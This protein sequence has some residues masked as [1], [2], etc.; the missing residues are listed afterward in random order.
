MG[1]DL[2]I[3]QQ[4]FA[5]KKSDWNNKDTKSLQAIIAET[6][7]NVLIGTSTKPGAFTKEIVEEMAKHV[8]R[9]IIFPLSNPTRLHEAKP[10]DI[11]TW[12]KGR[13]L[14]ATGSPF[15]PIEFEG[16]E[17]E[18][19][20]CNNSVCFPGIGLGGVL[21]KTRKLSDKMLVAA[22]SALAN[23]AP[24]LKDPNKGLVPGVE[25]ARRVSIQIAKAVI[26]QSQ[27]EDLAQ[28]TDIPDSDEDLEEWVKAQ[29][30]EPV[31]RPY[32]KA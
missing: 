6:M 22:V 13:A 16:Q 26:R 24:A 32:Q 5:R 7:P 30:W 8:D 23:E 29:M 28:A 15:P 4:P 25:D 18:V 17:Y 31:Y 10:E 14:I 2:S 1:E 19:A 20:E 21:S 3:A 9:P 11:N 12:T 27:K